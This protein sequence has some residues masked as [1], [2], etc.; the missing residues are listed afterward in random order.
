M[1]KFTLSLLIVLFLLSCQPMAQKNLYPGGFGDARETWTIMVYINAQ[2][3]GLI[4]EADINEMEFAELSDGIKVIVLFDPN[5]GSGVKLYKIQQDYNMSSITSPRLSATINSVTLNP[6]VDN[7]QINMSSEITLRDFVN[8]S[9]AN[10]PADHYGVIIWGHGDG[11]RSAKANGAIPP[12]GVDGFFFNADIA[13]ALNGLG[14]SAVGFD[15]CLQGSMETLWAFK[16]R[17]DIPFFVGSP[18]LEDGSGWRYNLFLEVLDKSYRRA[19][20]FV[21]SAVSS[22]ADYYIYNYG[23]TNNPTLVGY[24]LPA[25]NNTTISSFFTW[26]KASGGI[27]ERTRF[28]ESYLY[29]DYSMR[30]FY[31]Y[32]TKSQYPAKSD[33]TAMLD[34]LIISSWSRSTGFGYNGIGIRSSSSS[35]IVSYETRDIN[36]DLSPNGWY[37]ILQSWGQ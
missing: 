27:E 36:S 18:N 24:Y 10:F 5:D 3:S 29:Q 34:N 8:F 12:Y 13:N 37:D 31:E 20:D 11:W 22:Y 15:T 17:T 26:I 30:N 33:M 28:G 6:L 14:I 23:P 32:V 7:T 1:K 21:Y 35:S 2:G 19:V 25:F 4:G 16:K 9:K